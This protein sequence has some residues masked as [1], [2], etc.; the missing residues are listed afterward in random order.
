[1]TSNNESSRT[2]I[3]VAIIGGTTVLIAAIRQYFS[4]SNATNKDKFASGIRE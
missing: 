3:I 2:Q 1:M 4:Q